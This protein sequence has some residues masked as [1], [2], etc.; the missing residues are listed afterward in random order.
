[1]ILKYQFHLDIRK[2]LFLFSQFCWRMEQSTSCII[3]LQ[4]CRY[5]KKKNRLSL[6]ES[7]IRR[8]CFSFFPLVSHLLRW[9]VRWVELSWNWR[10]LIPGKMHLY[11]SVI[12]TGVLRWYYLVLLRAPWVYFNL[13][14]L[15]ISNDVLT[16][17]IW[18]PRIGQC[19]DCWM[20][21]PPT[22]IVYA[23]SGLCHRWRALIMCRWAMPL[24]IV[25]VVTTIS[26]YFETGIFLF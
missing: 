13:S 12:L 21:C 5:V 24:V 16:K 1:M 26:I 9:V 23:A 2:Y 25:C 17:Q 10:S 19:R 18:T 8:S 20:R 14:S 6:Q 7:G 4:Q 11:W 22:D 3:T 15:I